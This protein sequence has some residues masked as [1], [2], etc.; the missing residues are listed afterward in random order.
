MENASD[1][2]RDGE[3]CAFCDHPATA[4]WSGRRLIAVCPSC[5]IDVLPKL[6]ADAIDLTAASESDRLKLIV[7]QMKSKFWKALSLRFVK[8]RKR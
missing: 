5:A 1:N 7:I 6:A 3:F 8:E 2:P 4:A